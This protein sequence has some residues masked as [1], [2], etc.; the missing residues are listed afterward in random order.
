MTNSR[1]KTEIKSLLMSVKYMLRFW[2]HKD[3]EKTVP[4]LKVLTVW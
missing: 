4:V 1:N 3:E 2:E